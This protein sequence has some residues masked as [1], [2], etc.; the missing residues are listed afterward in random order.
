MEHTPHMPRTLADLK[1]V[2]YLLNVKPN[3]KPQNIADGWYADVHGYTGE[4]VLCKHL[5]TEKAM[6][7]YM[8]LVTGETFEPI[9]LK[10]ETLL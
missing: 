7:V 4:G 10:W 3:E 6:R 2:E 9:Y 5:F 1:E 8:A